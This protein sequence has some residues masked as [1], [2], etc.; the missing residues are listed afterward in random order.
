MNLIVEQLND[1][2]RQ[3]VRVL[4]HLDREIKALNGLGCSRASVEKI[5]D[6]LDYIQVYP[7]IWHHPTEDLIYEVLLQKN[8][9]EPQ[10]LADCIEDHGVLEL[11]TENLH[12]YLEQFALGNDGVRSRLVKAGSD[13][14]KRQLDHMEH[15]QQTL[16]PLMEEFLSDGDWDTIKQQLKS[17]QPSGRELQLEHYRSLYRNIADSSAITAH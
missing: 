12:S 11:L 10:R 9:P 6:I 17:R 4:Y 14:V 16:F 3:L 5:L 1:D 8:I 7:E 15:E 2:H 13:Y